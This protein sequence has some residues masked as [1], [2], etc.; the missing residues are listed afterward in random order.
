MT[1]ANVLTEMTNRIVRKFDPVRVLLFGSRARGE[2]RPDS[3]IDLLVELPECADRR[4]TTSAIYD[5]LRDLDLRVGRDIV[6]TTPEEI[7]RRGDLIGTVLRPA[8]RE[9]VVLYD[10]GGGDTRCHVSEAEI[11][12]ETRRWMRQAQDDLTVAEAGLTQGV[13]GETWSWC[14]RSWA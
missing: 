3:D 5:A 2:A 14:G 7:A 10:A 13:I 11:A 1:T 12:A 9:G 8:L 6:V 4:G